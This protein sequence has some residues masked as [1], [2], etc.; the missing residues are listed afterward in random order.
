MANHMICIG[1]DMSDKSEI[2]SQL[3]QMFKQG[4]QFGVDNGVYCFWKGNGEQVWQQFTYEGRFIGANPH[5]QGESRV[6]VVVEAMMPHKNGTPLDGGLLAR[7]IELEGI[8]IRADVP[9]A[10]MYTV[11][12][13]L[14]T[15]TL[16]IAAFPHSLNFFN[17]E[18][19]YF[20]SQQGSN[21]KFHSRS[22]FPA[23][24]ASNSSNVQEADLS[25]A[26]I[27]GC[28]LKAESR[29]NALTGRSYNWALLETP[30]GTIDVVWDEAVQPLPSSPGGILSG[31][32]WLSTLPV[33]PPLPQPDR[34]LMRA[35]GCYSRGLPHT[36]ITGH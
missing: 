11:K 29:Q 13:D 9:N 6:K 25:F 32:F 34:V 33:D 8:E 17:S 4:E 7:A 28:I 26:N 5:F 1:F 23:S 31:L 2:V 3:E 10:K 27:T 16:Q 15:A 18:E 14:E 12:K 35:D 20:K 22:W 19:A 36:P 24:V 21:L 30:V